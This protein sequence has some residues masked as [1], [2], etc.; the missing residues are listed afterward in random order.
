MITLN[1]NKSVFNDA[2]YPYLMDYSH[3]YEVY[4]LT[5]ARAVVNHT[6]SHKSY[7][8][9]ACAKSENCLSYER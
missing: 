8:L 3:R 2:Y 1:I 7:C 5:E 9:N 6:L 4:Y